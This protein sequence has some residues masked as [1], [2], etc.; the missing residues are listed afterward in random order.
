MSTSHLCRC[1]LLLLFSSACYSD[2]PTTSSYD[3]S[4]ASD[5]DCVIVTTGPRCRSCCD[6]SALNRN[7]AERYETDRRNSTCVD[8][9]PFGQECLCDAGDPICTSGVCELGHRDGG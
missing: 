2:E 3:K 7:D 6:Y 9:L 5:Q 8:L 1:S 4:C